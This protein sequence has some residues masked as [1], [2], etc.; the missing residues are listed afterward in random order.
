MR[1]RTGEIAGHFP[2]VE[3][4]AMSAFSTPH[5][6]QSNTPIQGGSNANV[7]CHSGRSALMRHDSGPR[8]PGD[9]TR[10]PIR[11]RARCKTVTRCP[12]WRNVLTRGRCRSVVFPRRLRD[13]RWRTA[14]EGWKKRVAFHV[15]GRR[16]KR[17]N[18]LTD[19][20]THRHTDT[21]THRLFFVS[22]CVCDCVCERENA[23]D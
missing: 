15:K 3:D 6:C 16:G 12:C 23:R 10:H 7:P 22:V 2:W 17:R 20:Q 14:S 9:T 21:Q 19:R 8:G 11:A 5:V 18:R 13:T 1:L 4:G